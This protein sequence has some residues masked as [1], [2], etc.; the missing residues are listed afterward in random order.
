MGKINVLSFDVANLIAAGEVVERPS[1]VLKE[2]IENSI[3]AGATEVVAEIKRGGVALIRVSDNGCG[4]D[5]ED[6]PVA[7]QRHATSKIHGK[8]DLSSIMTLGFRG[9]ALAAISSVSEVTIITKTKEAESA[10]MLTSEG[11]HVIDIT[12]V[13]AA[14]GTTVVVENLFYNVP[15]RRKFLK[16]DATEAM[17][18][19][20]LVERVAL[21]RPDISIQL[22]IDGEEKF[23]TPG[24]G[25]LLH[26]ISAVLGRD[27]AKKTLHID[28]EANGIRVTGYIGTSENVR[29]NRN[30]ENF[31]ING[32]YVKSLTAAAALEK[33]YTSYIAPECFPACVISLSMSPSSVD[34]NVHPAKLEVKFSD[35]RPVFEAVYHTVRR[36]LESAAYRPEMTLGKDALKDTRTVGAFV[37][38]GEKPKGEQIT[39]GATPPPLRENPYRTPPT[40]PSYDAPV[41]APRTVSYAPPT[42][43]AAGHTDIPDRLSVASGA[44]HTQTPEMTPRESLDLLRAYRD[45]SPA[46]TPPPVARPTESAPTS[47]PTPDGQTPATPF[48][49]TSYRYVGEA[50]DCYLMVEVGDDL[51]VIDKHAAHER[52]LFEEIKKS[53][54]SDGRVA[55]QSLLL[56]LPVSLTPEELSAATEYQSEL[57]SVGFEYDLDASGV[58]LTAIPDAIGAS[59]AADLF[60][61]MTAEIAAGR[62]TPA[63]TEAIRREKAL[64]QIA[65]KAAIKGG[66]HYERPVIDWLIAKVLSLPDIIVCPHG[67]PIAY[68][69]S[70]REL[71]RRFDRI[72]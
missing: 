18:V 26:T 51:L 40:R 17:N 59:D 57:L 21:S 47:A 8:E 53:H 67:R 6:L 22:L 50:F 72:K 30:L 23:K 11:G 34:V 58:S 19:A 33:A 5:K 31:F 9:E 62:G 20:A 42:Q 64:Y 55:S 4:M 65:C 32:R 68:R 39:L 60:V 14:D 37:P 3:D 27:F 1:S 24:D 25:D 36:T 45:A 38:L 61:S 69:L 44:G 54:E 71:D 35:E 48:T 41:S 12:E 16:K 15:A 28:G 29:K 46:P 66:R 43:R 10:S 49:D 2:L 56:P 52:I 70:K 13:G 7:L 63:N